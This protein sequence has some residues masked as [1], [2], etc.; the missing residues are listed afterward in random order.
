MVLKDFLQFSVLFD[1]GLAIGLRHGP[2]LS[3]ER[4]EKPSFLERNR[5]ID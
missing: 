5:M 3:Q 2:K 1:D 4:R